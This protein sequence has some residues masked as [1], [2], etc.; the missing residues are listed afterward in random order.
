MIANYGYTN[1]SGDYFITIDTEQCDGCSQ[2]VVACP[3]DVLE[4]IIDDYD[5]VVA[6][7]NEEHRNKL[8]YSCRPCK[9]SIKDV[10]LPCVAACNSG[11]ITH[12]W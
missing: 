3:Q 12:S 8:K 9:A 10:P 2:C 11:A 1:G 7:V 4:T 6:A 5:S